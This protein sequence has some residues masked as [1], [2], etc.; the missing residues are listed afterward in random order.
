[1]R[2]LSGTVAQMSTVLQVP[3]LSRSQIAR[4]KR[5]GYL[6]LEGVLDPGMCGRV[7]TRKVP[8]VLSL[9]VQSSDTRE[10]LAGA[11]TGRDVG[12][13]RRA[14]AAHAVR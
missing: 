8:V 14:Y 12:H 2:S 10:F 9:L 11:A 13:H 1:M 3:L 5:D 6:I 4:F 7:R